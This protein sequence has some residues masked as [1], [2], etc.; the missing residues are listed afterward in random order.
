MNQTHKRAA[1]HRRRAYDKAKRAARH[2]R[3]AYDKAKRAARHKLESTTRLR[4]QM[5]QMIR[6]IHRKLR[7]SLDRSLRRC[8][9]EHLK[10]FG[11]NLMTSNPKPFWQFIKSLRQSSDCASALITINDTTTSVIDKEDALTNQIH[12]VFNKQ[13]SRS[14]PTLNSSPTKSMLP[15][16]ISTEG[17]VQL[18]I[19]LKSPGPD[20]T[21]PTFL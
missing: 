12:S 7:R 5:L 14:I 13:D 2:K 19:E 8:R 6:E 3:R 20:C 9:S 11:D 15:I 4:L 10:A 18:L 17:V 21:T 16:K 1:R